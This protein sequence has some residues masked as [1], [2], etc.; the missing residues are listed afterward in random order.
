MSTIPEDSNETIAYIVE[1]YSQTTAKVEKEYW[2]LWNQPFLNK[3]FKDTPADIKARHS[4][5][6]DM[7]RADYQTKQPTTEA[8]IIA[9]GKGGISAFPGQA[10]SSRIWVINTKTK[11]KSCVNIDYEVI[12]K[13][14]LEQLLLFNQY[15]GVDVVPQSDGWMGLD[16]RALPL[17]DPQPISS[18]ATKFFEKLKIPVV[19]IKQ[20]GLKDKRSG[21]TTDGK[22]KYADIRC[23]RD[24]TIARSSITEKEYKGW[25]YNSGFMMFTDNTNE[26]EF[27]TQDGI[28]VP[29][30]LVCYPHPEFCYPKYTQGDAY[31]VIR[32][33]QKKVLRFDLC[34][35]DAHRIPDMD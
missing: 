7:L 34:Y 22:Y 14:L 29:K 17:P 13:G 33:D 11:T 12:E 32:V 15:S 26:D 21:T 24:V 28:S 16:D 10:P 31:G 1:K 30:S 20:L 27:T 25:K 23:L 5:T 8:V 19:T 6:K 3:M 18:P 4:Y 2:K 35:F 9:F